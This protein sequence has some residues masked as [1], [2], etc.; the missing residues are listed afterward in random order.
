MQPGLLVVKKFVYLM[1]NGLA[2]NRWNI[3][4]KQPRLFNPFLHVGYLLHSNTKAWNENLVRFMLD[5]ASAEAVLQKPLFNCVDSGLMSW[6]GE[7]S[8][9]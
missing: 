8:G 1:I 4:P 6:S 7:K 3:Q 9:V 5:G 2:R